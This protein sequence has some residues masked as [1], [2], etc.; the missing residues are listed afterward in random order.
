MNNKGFSLIG[1]IVGVVVV[2]VLGAGGWYFIQRGGEDVVVDDGGANDGDSGLIRDVRRCR[3]EIQDASS[4]AGVDF[5][6]YFI[7]NPIR[8]QIDGTHW[9]VVRPQ[10]W[11]GDGGGSPLDPIQ[12]LSLFVEDD[13]GD[14]ILVVETGLLAKS[15]AYYSGVLGEPPDVFFGKR[16][17]AVLDVYYSG[18][19][20]PSG[21]V[22]HHLVDLSA[23]RKLLA[24]SID[25]KLVVEREGQEWKIAF[26]TEWLGDGKYSVEGISVN[27][28]I[29]HPMDI[30]PDFNLYPPY[31]NFGD[32]VF[33]DDY[34]RVQ[35]NV[36]LYSKLEPMDFGEFI[37]DLE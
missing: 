11:V 23:G 7:A 26:E 32:V 9:L 16:S 29:V 18:S 6:D 3:G 28:D 21:F 2:L 13:K 27:G 35:F 17:G 31:P 15:G 14:S 12:H 25:D 36:D 4:D 8:C 20:D 30:M 22:T 33:L 1:V 24:Y 37:V 34:S 19:T 10:R 5:I